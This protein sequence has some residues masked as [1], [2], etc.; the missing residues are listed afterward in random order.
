MLFYVTC[1][2]LRNEQNK[3]GKTL[4]DFELQTIRRH[5]E[6]ENGIINIV[7]PKDA[8]TIGEEI[9]ITGL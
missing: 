5:A 2:E 4:A 1:I 9:E 6:K 3:E 8:Y 7:R